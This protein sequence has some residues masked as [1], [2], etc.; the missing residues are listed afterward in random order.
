MLSDG[1][2]VFTW[3]AR[4]QVAALNGVSLQYDGFGRRTKNLQNTS[5]LF[6]GANAVQEL[7]GSTPAANLINGGI[8]EIF[9]RSDSAGAYTPL[10]DALGS[11]VALVDGSGN[12]VTQYSYDPFGNTTLSGAANAN[13]SQYA[14]RENEGNGL[15]YMRAR[16]YST[17]LGRFI[18]EDPLGFAGGDVN[19]HAYTGNNPVNFTDRRG[20]SRDCFTTNC[21]GLPKGFGGRKD[22]GPHR[23][24][25]LECFT[26]D[27]IGAAWGVNCI[28]GPKGPIVSVDMDDGTTIF[29]AYGGLQTNAWGNPKSLEQHFRDHGSDFGSGSEDE[30]AQQ[31]QDFFLR[32]QAEGLPTKIDEDGVIRVFDP[33]TNEFGSYN[34]NGTTRT[35]F[36]PRSPTYF[37]RQPGAEPVIVP[38]G[39]VEVPIQLELFP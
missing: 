20:L 17:V 1:S 31:A 22:T 5:F 23:P 34:S 29:S 26:M 18:N 10:K 15:Y 16:Y 8:D 33:A 3:N 13:P 4:N 2:N 12:L 7:S 37:A 25:W 6:D 30:Y 28:Q 9:T 24:N 39:K 27:L 14:G 11:T 38:S 36:G 32:S 21:G 19:P 35:Y